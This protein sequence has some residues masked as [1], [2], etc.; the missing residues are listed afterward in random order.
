[1]SEEKKPEATGEEKAKGL[2][3]AVFLSQLS[4]PEALMIIEGHALKKVE[5]DYKLLSEDQKLDLIKKADAEIE[6][7]GSISLF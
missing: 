6:R 2:M 5:G 7:S 3:F 1:M 4:Y